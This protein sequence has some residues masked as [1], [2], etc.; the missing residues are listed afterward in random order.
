MA[1]RVESI[2][3]SQYLL[4]PAAELV[5]I[6]P[7]ITRAL[8]RLCVRETSPCT[9]KN[10]LWNTAALV[11]IPAWYKRTILICTDI[12][13]F[14]FWSVHGTSPMCYSAEWCPF[15]L[16]IL[17]AS[18]L[19]VLKPDFKFCGHR[20][21]LL[22]QLHI[23]PCE[24]LGI[25]YKEQ[26]MHIHCN[27]FHQGL[28]GFCGSMQKNGEPSQQFCPNVLHKNS[29][30]HS[31]WQRWLSRSFLDYYQL[32][33]QWWQAQGPACGIRDS[34]PISALNLWGVLVSVVWERSGEVGKWSQI[35]LLCSISRKG[36]G[37]QKYYP[38]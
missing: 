12:Y 3:P 24:A 25:P 10:H 8:P 27:T 37:E 20:H 26:C 5:C 2:C 30:F 19:S 17:L 29:L 34:L 22:I 28:T 14:T 36:R 6:P 15:T 38:T 23:P 35:L 1:I 32:L 18:A 21:N 11:P 33:L 31:T 7:W 16:S 4:S 9:A 13:P